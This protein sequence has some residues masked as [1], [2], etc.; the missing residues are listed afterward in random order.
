M[1]MK[2]CDNCQRS[3]EEVPIL[4]YY[5]RGKECYVCTRCLPMLIHG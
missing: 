1:S 5:H 4:V 3:D 2:S